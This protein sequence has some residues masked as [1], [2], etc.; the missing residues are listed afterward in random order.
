MTMAG[1]E[2]QEFFT[3]LDT[4][5]ARFAEKGMGV[6]QAKTVL[7]EHPSVDPVLPSALHLAPVYGQAPR[8][9]SVQ[10]QGEPHGFPGSTEPNVKRAG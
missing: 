8:V 7:E 2:C 6:R 9:H 10:R 1:G 5:E 4:T 3:L